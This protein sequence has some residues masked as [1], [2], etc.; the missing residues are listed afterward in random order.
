MP[1]LPHT[2]DAFDTGTRPRVLIVEDDFIIAMELEHRLLDG[3]IEVVGTAITAGEAIS[4]AEAERPDLVI[5]DIR[6]AGRR[7]G[8]EA[9]IE[10]FSTF[11]IRSIFASAHADNETRKRAAP[12]YPI[13]WLQKPYS[14]DDLLLLL[15]SFIKA[16]IARRRETLR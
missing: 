11:A 9:A 14:A 13:G 10:I 6:L 1:G 8:V 3:G 16:E 7:D 15:R 2:D 4:M 5:M 12:A